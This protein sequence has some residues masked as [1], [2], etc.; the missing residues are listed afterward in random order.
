[1]KKDPA[2]PAPAVLGLH[3]DYLNVADA[4]LACQQPNTA[5]LHAELWCC[6]AFATPRLTEEDGAGG[7]RGAARTFA[8]LD[9]VSRHQRLLF[10]AYRRVSEE[11]GVYGV[12]S[13]GDMRMGAMAGFHGCQ[14]QTA[15][16]SADA[17][18]QSTASSHGSEVQLQLAASLRHL[19]LPHVLRQYLAGVV[20]S[21]PGSVRDPGLLDAQYEVR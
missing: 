8:A 12:R 3:L 6:N 15:A 13:E 21:Q 18:L 10:D 1:M 14:W 17:V 7:G 11:D 20:R 9:T 2:A 5:M 4:A 16:A 19:G